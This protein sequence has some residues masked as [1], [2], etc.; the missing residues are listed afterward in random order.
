MFG[1][2]NKEKYLKIAGYM[3]LLLGLFLLL[4]NGSIYLFKLQAQPTSNSFAIMM[5]CFGALFVQRARASK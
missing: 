3:M 2:Q 5:V 4:I 1:M